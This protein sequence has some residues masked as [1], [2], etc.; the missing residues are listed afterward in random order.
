MG[1]QKTIRVLLADDHSVVRQGIRRVLE[2]TED[3]DVV[4]EAGDGQQALDLVGSLKPDV[5]LCDIRLP[6]M[7]GIDVVRQAKDHSLG[8]RSVVLSAHDEDDYV[9]EAMGAGASGYLLKTMDANRLPEA[10]RRAH[11]GETVLYP[12]VSEQFSRLLGGSSKAVKQEPLTSREREILSLAAQ[13]SRNQDIA[14]RLGLSVRTVEGHFARIFVKLAVSSRLEAVRVAITR[15]MVN[16]PG[17]QV[18]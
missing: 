14:E 13:G 1:G 18:S 8:T 5:L 10:V 15:G 12:P 17:N 9:L 16:E 2:Q 6:I 7:N 3:I 11:S 4:G